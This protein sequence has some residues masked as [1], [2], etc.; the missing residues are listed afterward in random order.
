VN[1]IGG[2]ALNALLFQFMTQTLLMA[3][4]AMGVEH[5]CAAMPLK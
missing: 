5:W 4:R 3:L 2:K 1:S